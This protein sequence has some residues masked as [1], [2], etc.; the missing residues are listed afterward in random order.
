MGFLF[1]SA[2]DIR[3]LFSLLL[4]CCCCFFY[5]YLH[6]HHKLLSIL[7]LCVMDLFQCSS[8]RSICCLHLWYAKNE[9]TFVNAETAVSLWAFGEERSID[10]TRK[11]NSTKKGIKVKFIYHPHI[12]VPFVYPFHKWQ[13]LLIEIALNDRWYNSQHFFSSHL[14]SEC[15]LF[16]HKYFAMEF[17][18]FYGNFRV[19]V[20]I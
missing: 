3:A 2:T 5:R 6:L 13:T 15:Y 12:I 16:L 1:Q 17:L 11:W 9:N 20:L 10:T 4:F 14:L 8:S 18:L 19:S 7:L